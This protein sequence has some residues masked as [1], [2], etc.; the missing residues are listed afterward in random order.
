MTTDAK[1]PML[2]SGGMGVR[3]SWWP[4]ARIVSIMGGLG[5]VSGTGLEV[6]YPRLLQDG[7]PGGNV[8]AAFNE[9]AAR[10]PSLAEGLKGLYDKYYIEGGKPASQPYKPVPMWR[11]SRVE[12][13]GTP[14]DTFWEPSKDLQLMSLAS[15]FAEVWLAKR[16]HNGPI[17]INFLRKVERPL[18]WALYGAML[19]G[20]DYVLVGA[21]NPYEF[22]GMIRS[23]SRHEPASLGF[24]VFGAT[25]G[26]GNFS[27]LAR[28]ASLG[29]KGVPNLPQPKF[30]AIVSSYGL[31][32]ALHDNPETRPHGFVVEGPEA[33]GHSAPPGKMKFD[34]SGKQVLVYTD[35]D[36][37]DIPAIASIGLPFWLAGTYGTPERLK[38]A[39]AAGAAGV[40]FGTLAALSGQSG[41]EPALR[42]QTLRMLA[43]GE[44]KVVN[45]HVSPTGFPFKVAQVPGTISDPAVYSKRRRVCDIGLL[46]AAYLAPNGGVE[47]RCP[48]E[49]LE[50]FKAKG[51]RPQNTEG[52][53][54]LCNA[55]LAAAGQPQ[56][57]PDG[58]PE[59][60]IV[61]LGEDLAPVKDMIA[62][63]PPGQEG[64][65]IGKAI[66]YL[67]S[68]LKEA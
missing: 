7:N 18:P 54:C 25:S 14:P 61:T 52:K 35:E 51:G 55:L 66:Q 67:K 47:F 8:R 53:V 62:G 44:L 33:G 49:P 24:K 63:L 45:S 17:G 4:L 60:G 48:A 22:P 1:Y 21:G 58:Y 65:S 32:K 59:P 10:Q 12:G 57:H 43:S 15:N 30:L 64:Y 31:A 13:Y 9:L 6:V 5:V 16:D 27:V 26:S 2:I 29:V 20:I 28:P 34:A 50:S 42:A 68:G 39:L 38:A 56:R 11:L 37:A 19:A 23:L 40:Q 41:F 46:A 3:V 36:R